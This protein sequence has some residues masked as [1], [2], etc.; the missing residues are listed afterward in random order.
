MISRSVKRY[1]GASLIAIAVAL[2]LLLVACGGEEVVEVVESSV[3]WGYSG[4]GAPENWASLS[5]DNERCESGAQQ[6]PID[7]TGYAEGSSPPISFSYRR[8]AE[9]VTN[10]GTAITVNYPSGNRLGLSERTYQ[11][12]AVTAHTPSEHH[13]DGKSYPLELQLLHSQTFGDVAVVSMLFEIGDEN[14]VVQEIIDNMPSEVGTSEVTGVLNARGLATK[15][16]GYYSYKGSM[17]NPPCAEP[18]DW[19]VMLELGTVSQAQVDALQNLTGANNRPLQ[20]LNGREITNSGS[21]T[22]P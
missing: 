8:E 11:L 7:I 4:A 12:E 2:P 10:A 5:A 6:S 9:S 13:I 17:T 21:R 20:A 15:D 19:F 3:E 18:V 22:G 16:L 14:P 1:V